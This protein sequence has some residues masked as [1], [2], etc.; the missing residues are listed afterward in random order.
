M[1]NE[2]LDTYLQYLSSQPRSAQIHCDKQSPLVST[3][4]A[5][6]SKY[7]R[8]VK[9]TYVTPD[10]RE[11]EFMFYDITRATLN[12]YSVKPAV[13]DLVLTMA[14]VV[15]LGCCYLVLQYFPLAYNVA[16]RLTSHQHKTKIH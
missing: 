16:A 3:L 9:V 14:I 1:S 8:D 10:K 11:P 6:L 5:A 15:Y 13:F 2:F 12:V 7:T 4:K